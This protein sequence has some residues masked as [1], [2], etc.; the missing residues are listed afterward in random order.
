MTEIA[1]PTTSTLLE[2]QLSSLPPGTSS[3]YP[4]PTA[5]LSSQE[6]SGSQGGL[7][8]FLS[9]M[10]LSGLSNTVVDEVFDPES[11]EKDMS[12]DSD[13]S[14]EGDAFRQKAFSAGKKSPARMVR[15]RSQTS[16]S[17]SVDMT[18]K[19]VFAHKGKSIPCFFPG[20][21]LKT[22]NKGLDIEFFSELGVQICTKKKT[23]MYDDFS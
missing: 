15:T 1:P 18:G 19:I 6:G 20:K 2:S 21:V 23:L 8:G 10:P 7:L 16:Q 4:I 22:T 13:E 12:E 3:Q 14:D 9:S 5:G 17:N 11:I